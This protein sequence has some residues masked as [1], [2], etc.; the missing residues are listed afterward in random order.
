MWDKNGSVAQIMGL[1]SVYKISICLQGYYAFSE[2]FRQCA[3]IDDRR[4]GCVVVAALNFTAF[5]DTFLET[6]IPSLAYPSLFTQQTT[7]KYFPC[8]RGPLENTCP[9]SAELSSLLDL[10]KASDTKASF[11]RRLVKP[12]LWLAWH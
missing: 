1:S 10:S 6:A 11:I 8:L 7:R 3:S 4:A 12:V 2:I 9:K 5:F